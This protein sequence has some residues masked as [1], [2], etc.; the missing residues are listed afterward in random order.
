ALVDGAQNSDELTLVP[1]YDLEDSLENL[2]NADSEIFYGKNGHTLTDEPGD[3]GELSREEAVWVEGAKN[4][5]DYQF[6]IED[7]EEEGGN[8]GDN[9]NVDNDALTLEEALEADNGDGLPDDYTLTSG[10]V[11]L[12]ALSVDD[13]ED[14]L[15]DL[16]D[17]VDDAENSDDLTL[18]PSLTLKDTLDNVLDADDDVIEHME[19]YQLSNEQTDLG[20][21][22]GE[23]ASV[24]AGA[25][26]AG[27]Y[28]FSRE[29]EIEADEEEDVQVSASA[30]DDTF[31]FDDVDDIYDF[32]DDEDDQDEVGSAAIDGFGEEGND[33]L[34]FS[35]DDLNDLVEDATDSDAEPFTEGGQLTGDQLYVAADATS[36]QTDQA[37]FVFD[38]Q[39]GK[40]SFDADGN[41]GHEA[42]EIATLNGVDDLSTEDFNIA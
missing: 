4:A 5:D 16:D 21:L 24:V 38:T 40:L 25:A 27:D 36:A 13:A 11:E 31:E 8:D 12:G 39:T 15:D 14:A 32:D 20:E 41:G 37:A 42:V 28:T 33:T 34:K 26:N 6:E 29:I 9:G 2:Q 10:D 17:I 19:S 23:E 35:A 3:L 18:N 7:G 1:S 30:G 22:S